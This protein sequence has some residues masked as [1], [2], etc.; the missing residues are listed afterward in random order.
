MLQVSSARLGTYVPHPDLE[1]ERPMP[2][3]RNATVLLLPALLAGG[4]CAGI[5]S[6]QVTSEFTNSGQTLGNSDS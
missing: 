3:H 2:S 4:T 5:A 1:K 6:A